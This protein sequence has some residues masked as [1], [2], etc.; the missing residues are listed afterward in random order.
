[1]SCLFNSMSRHLSEDPQAIRNK[2]CDYLAINPMT[3]MG[4][5]VSEIIHLESGSGLE[6]YIRS[7]RSPCTWGGAIEIAAAVQI[8]NCSFHVK[9][10]RTGHWIEFI[11]DPSLNKDE[12][13]NK[14]GLSWTGGHYEPLVIN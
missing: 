1:M 10:E 14:Y 8:W 13:L 4:L 12:S 11:K 9:V 3:D 5:S 6:E 2:I 7:M